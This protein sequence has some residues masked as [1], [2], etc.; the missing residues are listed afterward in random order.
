MSDQPQGPRTTVSEMIAA[1][2]SLHPDAPLFVRGYEG[3]YRDAE[4]PEPIKLSLYVNEAWYYGPHDDDGKDPV[5]G[6][7]IDGR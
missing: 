6:F 1:L 7:L 2:S 3:G 5:D 4:L